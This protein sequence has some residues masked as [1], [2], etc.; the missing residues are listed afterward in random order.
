MRR[1][2]PRGIT[3][4]PPEQGKLSPMEL[5]SEAMTCPRC[6]G[7]TH[8]GFAEVVRFGSIDVDRVPTDHPRCDDDTC[9]GD[10]GTNRI[11]PP[12]TAD[13]FRREVEDLFLARQYAIIETR[14]QDWAEPAREILRQRGAWRGRS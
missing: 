9:T 14:P 13:Q 7:S 11:V 5:G 6:G 4:T 8:Q 3:G 1:L 10:D 2:T 12:P